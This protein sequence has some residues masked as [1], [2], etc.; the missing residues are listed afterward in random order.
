MKDLLYKNKALWLLF[1]VTGVTALFVFLL[2]YK[3]LFDQTFFY[4][5]QERDLERA[6][7]ILQGKM[8][9]FG[10][11]L[12]GGGNLPG[13]LYYFC[14]AAVLFFKSNWIGA[15]LMQLIFAA[16][17][18]IAGL[19]FFKKKSS[20]IYAL[21]WIILFSTAPMTF[22]FLQLFLNVSSLLPFCI[23]GLI[24]I[25]K[26]FNDVDEDKRSTSFILASL[27]IGLGL[28]FHYSIICL[29]LALLF[30]QIFSKKLN[31]AR[32]PNKTLAYGLLLFLLPSLPYIVWSLLKNFGIV[33]GDPGLYTGD[34]KNAPASLAYLLQFSMAGNPMGFWLGSL[35]KLIFTLPF[36]LIF[37]FLS[38][39]IQKLFL[40]N[41]EKNGS[42]KYLKPLVICLIFSTL[43]YLNW[44]FSGQAVRYTMPFYLI[45][46]F[47][48][49]F[50]YQWLINSRTLTIIFNYLTISFLV[51]FSVWVTIK[52]PHASFVK[53]IM[54]AL[55]S[56]AAIIIVS[57]FFEENGIYKRKT[58]LLSLMLIICTN[59]AQFITKDYRTLTRFHWALFLP[60][61]YEWTHI[62]EI[63]HKNTGWSYEEAKKRIYYV[64]HHFEQSPKMFLDQYVYRE[65]VNKMPIM[66]DGF[67]ISNRVRLQRSAMPMF[68]ERNYS[69][70]EPHAWLL[71]QNLQPEIVKGITSH[72]IIL[73]K[74]L[75][76]VILIIPYWVK[77][78]TY[79]PRYF[80]N[81]GEGYNLSEDDK[82]LSIIP[83][84]GGVK[85]M[86]AN[87]VLFKWNENPKCNEYCSTGATVRFEK[88]AEEKYSVKIRII[89]FTISQISPWIIPDWTEAWIKP[90]IDINCGGSNNHFPIAD[91]IGFR[92]TA[93]QNVGTPLL[94]GNNSFVGPFEKEIQ[95]AC[96][97][98]LNSISM[99]RLASKVERIQSE[100]IINPAP[101]TIQL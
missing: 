25:H 96:S 35:E 45:L 36:P 18:A 59:Q 8:I 42:L 30:M 80:H 6:R 16:I 83:G 39:L 14:L 82:V 49:V 11:E 81:S 88:I 101:L 43:P 69:K 55:L 52:F 92:R 20:P 22:R 23:F 78:T 87:E 48:T 37:I 71:H 31:L 2:D 46:L 32:V 100:L 66:P 77:S 44:Y 64:G 27:A 84:P 99:G 95:V 58:T 74:N 12:T 86:S 38:V 61:T 4:V 24:F 51:V 73:G 85:L 28:Q 9:F 50:T 79:T 90:Y 1:L 5:F 98:K 54:E 93:S 7:H 72:N 40:K 10:P 19:F 57:L 65:P 53:F 3:E 91:A 15:W 97:G 34:F 29:Y 75:S 17:G 70:F 68:I 56:I 41:T 89:G 33:L 26:T 67:F 62:W 76:N 63:V 47:I 60:Q 94:Q 21:L 13:P